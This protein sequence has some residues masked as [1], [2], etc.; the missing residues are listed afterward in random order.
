MLHL[1]QF[2]LLK[3]AYKCLDKITS[4]ENEIPRLIKKWRSS[5]FWLFQKQTMITGETIAFHT[6]YI[7]LHLDPRF[8]NIRWQDSFPV[9]IQSNLVVCLSF[10]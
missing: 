9:E 5:Y 4:N 6:K 1:T 2:K 10:S 8:H 7:S 3:S